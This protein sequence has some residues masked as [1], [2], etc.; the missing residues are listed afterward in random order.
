[1]TAKRSA[2][3]APAPKSSR[4]TDRLVHGFDRSLAH[5]ADDLLARFGEEASAV[6]RTEILEE[7][8][9]LIP[10]VPY[11]G[12]WRD[13]HASNL[14]FTSQALALHRVVL[15]HGG[16]VADS[17]WLLRRMMEAQMQRIPRLVR[18]GYGRFRFTRLGK[19]REEAAARKSQAREYP[20]DWVY[21]R[22]DGDGETF[23]FGVDNTECGT[24]KYL[25]AEDADELCPYICDL[26]YVAAKGMGVGVRRTKTL[27]WGCDRCDFRFSK[28]GVT[29]APWPPEFAERTCGEPQA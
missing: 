15:R 27:A 16:T 1:M 22:F 8:R 4:Q 17:G 26:E 10:G 19:W 11:L 9:R 20:G 5:V 18:H 13:G 29:S 7:Y 21:E 24:V 14:V 3:E 28:H 23:D 2:P 12:G 6:M 25:N